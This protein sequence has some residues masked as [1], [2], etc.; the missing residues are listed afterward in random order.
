MGG[1]SNKPHG[2]S[3]SEVAARARAAIDEMSSR[4]WLLAADC[5]IEPG[6]LDDLRLAALDATRS[7]PSW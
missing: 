6:R 7:W 5:S 4:W 1:I 3:A 2:V